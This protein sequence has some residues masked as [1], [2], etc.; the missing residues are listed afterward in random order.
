MLC[1]EF[2]PDPAC[3]TDDTIV[4]PSPFR[5]IAAYD[6]APSAAKQVSLVRGEYFEVLDSVTGAPNW[7]VVR[8]WGTDGCG[9]YVPVNYVLPAPITE[10][11]VRETPKNAAAVAAMTN[12]RKALV[13]DRNKKNA[14][15]LESKG[16]AP[17]V[18]EALSTNL[19][20]AL[21]VGELQMA[22]TDEPTNNAVGRLKMTARR[23]A[24]LRRAVSR[25]AYS[26][27]S[28]AVVQL[29]RCVRG[30]AP[31]DALF[32]TPVSGSKSS[33]WT[34]I[35][36]LQVSSSTLLSDVETNVLVEALWRRQGSCVA[37]GQDAPSS[38]VDPALLALAATEAAEIVTRTVPISGNEQKPQIRRAS[39]LHR[40]S[41]YLNNFH[42]AFCLP[43]PL[44]MSETLGHPQQ[45]LKKQSKP[46]QTAETCSKTKWFPAPRLAVQKTI[47]VADVDPPAAR[48]SSEQ[49]L[50]LLDM[51]STSNTAT[52]AAELFKLLELDEISK[53]STEDINPTA[54]NTVV[55]APTAAVSIADDGAGKTAIS[56]QTM[57][58]VDATYV[59]PA[60]NLLQNRA[61]NQALDQ[62]FLSTISQN[63]PNDDWPPASSDVGGLVSEQAD[64][65]AALEASKA[66]EA[67]RQKIDRIEEQQLAAAIAAS[68]QSCNSAPTA[69]IEKTAAQTMVEALQQQ[70]ELH[71]V[72]LVTAVSKA[73]S[74]GEDRGRL[75][76]DITCLT[77]GSIGAGSGT[78]AKPQT[79]RSYTLSEL[80]DGLP[81]GVNAAC[82]EISLSEEDFLKTLGCDREAF[83]RLPKWKQQA[84]KKKAGLF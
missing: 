29:H 83:A 49:Q 35:N 9:G 19:S 76:R 14:V 5:V 27:P 36:T 26:K 28:A 32:A 50:D 66:D 25:E 46:L 75:Q 43:L 54:S 8:P 45:Q 81:T 64:L 48:P 12:T 58:N 59:T 51:A 3:T 80:Q 44:L 31:T 68:V 69:A 10:A 60:T 7:W 1:T 82:K 63:F 11:I 61:Q 21:N 38:S 18:T 67:S 53:D 39:L 22:V 20:D 33:I 72:A 37:G 79:H 16:F 47:S 65:A 17:S 62:D 23:V 42:E 41:M 2:M 24:Q 84:R 30:D 74:A 77:V 70:T 6:F 52:D 13:F 78:Q 71:Q 4:S 73:D 15:S 57:H 34:A 40:R 56:L 55:V